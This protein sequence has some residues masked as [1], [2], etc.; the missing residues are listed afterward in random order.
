MRVCSCGSHKLSVH[1]AGNPARSPPAKA[2]QVFRWT[3]SCNEVTH[4]EQLQLW[5]DH[6]PE[7]PFHTIL[8]QYMKPLKDMTQ[9]Y[10]AH[11]LFGRRELGLQREII[12]AAYGN[13]LMVCHPLWESGKR[14]V[15]EKASMVSPAGSMWLLRVSQDQS[16]TGS[17]G[18]R[19][20]GA[21][22]C[23]A[24]ALCLSVTLAFARV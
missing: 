6:D 21:S 2:S 11:C 5:A 13:Y 12:K 23:F 18:S 8:M 22:L 9:S 17:E 4:R 15:S 24:G 7:M 19:F 20:P 10:S 16:E 3:C 14:K 1:S